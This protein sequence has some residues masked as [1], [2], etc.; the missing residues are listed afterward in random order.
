MTLYCCSCRHAAWKGARR[1]SEL[2]QLARSRRAPGFPTP[3]DRGLTHGDCYWLVQVTWLPGTGPSD[4]GDANVQLTVST[5]TPPCATVTVA[6][7]KATSVIVSVQLGLGHPGA[8]GMGL[9]GPS[10]M[11]SNGV[12]P[13]LIW[14]AGV[15]W[16]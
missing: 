9:T 14:L 5:V 8:P 1:C 12:L 10:V 13:F 7:V 4:V 2:H 15:D 3:N 11:T 16:V 6:L